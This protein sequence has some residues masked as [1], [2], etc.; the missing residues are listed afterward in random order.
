MLSYGA[1]YT[2]CRIFNDRP[3][4]AAA[5]LGGVS[6]WLLAFPFIHASQ[7]YRLILA[8]LIACIYA[9]LSAWELGR[10]NARPLTSPRVAVALLLGLAAFN[11][12]R[13]GLGITLTSVP[14]I[15][16]FASRWSPSMALL[17]VVFGPTLAFMLLSMAKESIEFE[18][19][20][21]ALVDPLTGAPNRRA[22]MHNAA[23]LLDG[24]E[25]RLASCLLFDLDNF[26]SIND[27]YGHDAGDR[28][29][30]VFGEIL[31]SHLPKRS[32]GRLGGEEFGA[33]LPIDSQAAARLADRIRHAFAAAGNESLDGA[34]KATVSVGCATGAGL[35]ANAMLKR[36]DAALY[37]AKRGG[38]N[39]VIAA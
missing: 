14:W 26:K 30:M 4:P 21:A 7:G 27:R 9:V 16:A 20:R 39:L 38:R 23:Q 2:G 8:S 37:R 28:V 25:G 12:S 36:A 19:K 15:D 24:L 32:F 5:A 35:D 10:H 29:L 11:L 13:A 1:L 3:A 6:V 22:F 33:V 31:A 17:L 34:A 18:Y